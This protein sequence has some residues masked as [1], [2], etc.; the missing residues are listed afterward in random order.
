MYLALTILL[1]AAASMLLKRAS[2]SEEMMKTIVTGSS[3]GCYGLAFVTYYAALRNFPVSVAYTVVTSGTI[4]TIVLSA[5]Y[6]LG[7]TLTNIKLTGS[8]LVIIGGIMLTR[9]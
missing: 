2:N 4:M 7:E 6:L 9:S 5:A 3:I 1:N 8:V